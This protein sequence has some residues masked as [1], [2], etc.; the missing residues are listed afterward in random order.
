MT[1][2]TNRRWQFSLRTLLL[3]GVPL[4]ALCAAVLIRD[5]SPIEKSVKIALIVGLWVV[6][7]RWDIRNRQKAAE[8]P[9]TH[10]A[11]RSWFSYSLRTLFIVVT[12]FACWLGW[13]V[14]LVN[15]RE[16]VQRDIAWR[17]ATFL[18]PAFHARRNIWNPKLAPQKPL[19]TLL[20]FF[21]AKPFG[22]IVLPR[23]EFTEAER[24]RVQAVFPEAEVSIPP[25]GWGQGMM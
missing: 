23:D 6:G 21:G 22:S 19:P 9:A 10:A 11:N 15:E 12:L 25:A 2:A 24:Q 1:H 13:N 5:D 20:S 7:L 17:G 8:L 18:T 16:R 3:W 14:H 4:A